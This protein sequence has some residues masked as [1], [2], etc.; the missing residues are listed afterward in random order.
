MIGLPSRLRSSVYLYPVL[1]Y[2]G[3]VDWIRLLD[4]AVPPQSCSCRTSSDSGLITMAALINE[5][6]VA[7]AALA[8]AHSGRKE[9]HLRAAG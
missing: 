5:P 3:H 6:A 7:N 2:T 8:T 1:A 4:E 9:I